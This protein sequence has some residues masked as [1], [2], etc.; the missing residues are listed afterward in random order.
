MILVSN[1]GRCV[2]TIS[3]NGNHDGKQVCSLLSTSLGREGPPL[4]SCARARRCKE[5]ENGYLNGCYTAGLLRHTP[6]TS[7]AARV[8]EV[9]CSLHSVLSKGQVVMAFAGRQAKLGTPHIIKH[10]I[11]PSLFLAE[12][13]GG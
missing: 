10:L 5:G 9:S 4:S 7:W 3:C 6:Y 12:A 2:V 8:V 11:K 13:Q 1:T